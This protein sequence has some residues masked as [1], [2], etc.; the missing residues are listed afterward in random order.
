MTTSAPATTK[1]VSTQTEPRPRLLPRCSLF[2]KVC[3]DVKLVEQMTKVV[4]FTTEIN[5]EQYG[6]RARYHLLVF[7]VV[8]SCSSVPH[9]QLC[10]S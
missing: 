6:L 1:L 2:L 7:V 9:Y 8:E 3:G 4:T 10:H 5:W